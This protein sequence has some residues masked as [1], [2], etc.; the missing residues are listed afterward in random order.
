MVVR[1]LNDPEIVYKITPHHAHRDDLSPRHTCCFRRE[2]ISLLLLKAMTAVREV[3][4]RVTY[5]ATT[6]GHETHEIQAMKAQIRALPED[7][8]VLQ[9]QR[10]KD[11]DRLTSDIQHEHDRFRELVRNAEA[12]G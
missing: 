3:N 4:E 7:V 12:G 6:Q 2:L 8:D 5:L 1:G 9:R 11:E 10:I